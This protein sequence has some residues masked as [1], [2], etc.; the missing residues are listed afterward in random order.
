MTVCIGAAR[1]K[2]EL[3]QTIEVHRRCG[4]ALN[5][6]HFELTGDSVTEC[7]GGSARLSAEDLPRNYK[8]RT[9]AQTRVSAPVGG[10]VSSAAPRQS[11]CDPRLNAVQSLDIAFQLAEEYRDCRSRTGRPGS[12]PCDA[13]P[14]AHGARRRAQSACGSRSRSHFSTLPIGRALMRSRRCAT[15]SMAAS[16]AA[17]RPRCHRRRPRPREAVM[18]ARVVD[19]VDVHR[20]ALRG[21]AGATLSASP[22]PPARR[23]P[24]YA[25]SRLYVA[26]CVLNSANGRAAT[27][28][29]TSTA[30][31]APPSAPKKCASQ[32]A[33]SPTSSISRYRSLAGS[34]PAASSARPTLSYHAPSRLRSQQSCSVSDQ[35][36]V[37]KYRSG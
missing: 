30:A 29:S 22:P 8:V 17:I 33:M 16:A 14:T 10:C 27:R 19:E 4:R 3:R 13:R 36:G 21:Q 20:A 35:A 6:V 7:I 31:Q 1:I 37:S 32:A 28:R 15:S 11:L 18:E 26:R 5:G 12:A 9:R 24:P 2:A 34:R 25:H 23:A